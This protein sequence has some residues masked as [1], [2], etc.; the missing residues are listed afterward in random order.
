MVSI[1]NDYC[2]FMIATLVE[3][4]SAHD[5]TALP[6]YSPE[7][8]SVMLN[9]SKDSFMNEFSVDTC[10]LHQGFHLYK[11]FLVSRGF[12][13]IDM[14]A[15]DDKLRSFHTL[16]ALSNKGYSLVFPT[17][18]HDHPTKTMGEVHDSILLIRNSILL[19]YMIE[20][21]N[22][23]TS[24]AI[25]SQLNQ[26]DKSEPSSSVPAKTNTFQPRKN[27]SQ[28]T[29]KQKKRN[30]KKI[31]ELIKSNF[32]NDDVEAYVDF[33]SASLPKKQKC[34]PA[35]D[36]DEKNDNEKL[37]DLVK[38]SEDVV[39]SINGIKKR[40]VTISLE[41]KVQILNVYDS[42]KKTLEINEQET[43]AVNDT[44]IA[45]ITHKLIQET[46]LPNVNKRTISRLN[47]SRGIILKKR[48]R[49]V[50]IEFEAELWA[51][52]MI[53]SYEVDNEVRSFNCLFNAENFMNNLK[54]LMCLICIVKSSQQNFILKK[55]SIY[56]V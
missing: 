56:F 54:F 28:L 36:N 14:F 44:Q 40:Y 5:F 17:V 49:K 3:R 11:R 27:F 38:N 2:A 42:V 16:K 7:A 53:C 30:A 10:A 31:R 48:G 20:P 15:E 29:L 12:L 9:Q 43:A 8:I 41:E 25:L 33:L 6:Q 32:G 1:V 22:Y 35:G 47:D 52:L 34:S 24:A 18:I 55:K 21:S 23:N 26:T 39:K 37:F 13:L 51:N 19:M 46:G 50:N 4:C 45:N